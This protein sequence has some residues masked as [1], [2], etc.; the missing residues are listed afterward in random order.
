MFKK[1]TK[2]TA[3]DKLT[4]PKSGV[5]TAQ[6]PRLQL[7]RIIAILTKTLQISVKK[8]LTRGDELKSCKDSKLIAKVE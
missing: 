7:E 1:T 2:G 5:S 3:S 4:D 8:F 6:P